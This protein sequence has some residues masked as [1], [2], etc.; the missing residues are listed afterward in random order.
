MTAPARRLI[1][2]LRAR[3]IRN[4]AV[5]TAMRNTPRHRFIDRALAAHAYDD[6]ALPIGENQTISQPFVVALMTEMLLNDA[7]QKIAA[8]KILE[9]GTGCGYQCAV[10]AQ[11]VGRVFTIERI[12][13]LYEQ[14]KLRLRDLAMTNIYFRHADG[15]DGWASA[16]PFDGILITAAANHAPPKLLDQLALG[17]KMVAPIGGRELQRLCVITRT[18]HGYTEKLHDAVRFVPMLDGCR[19]FADNG[20]AKGCAKRYVKG[21]ADEN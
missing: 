5:L 2:R 8:K 3:G 9:V 10:L 6:T 13:K 12:G 21:W 15:F 16:Q 11:L 20:H 4:E 14:A 19:P 18:P 17:G 7:P 1:A